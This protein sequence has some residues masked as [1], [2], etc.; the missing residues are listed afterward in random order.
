MIYFRQA[1]KET[2]L[3]HLDQS[4]TVNTVLD[5][6]QALLPSLTENY[7][8]ES[9]LGSTVRA[10]KALEDLRSHPKNVETTDQLMVMGIVWFI[11][12]LLSLA[13]MRSIQKKHLI[14]F[15]HIRRNR[16]LYEVYFLPDRHI[17]LSGRSLRKRSNELQWR[18]RPADT[19]T[20]HIARVASRGNVLSDLTARQ[21]SAS[22]CQS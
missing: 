3:H 11:T 14:I 2:L 12:F 6:L 19:T 21:A 20:D 4:N 8:K 5:L 9:P 1:C 15:I 17:R 13:L 10:Q 18:R 7:Q 16:V 22:S